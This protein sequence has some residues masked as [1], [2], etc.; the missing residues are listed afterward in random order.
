MNDSIFE[1]LQLIAAEVFRCPPEQVTLQSSAENMT[2][3]DSL[4]HLN[5]VLALEQEFGRRFT[6]EQID[7]MNCV[8]TIVE[9]LS[10]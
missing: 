7:R 8:S 6:P 9:I 5:L 2:T 1:R 4:T 10:A 3:W